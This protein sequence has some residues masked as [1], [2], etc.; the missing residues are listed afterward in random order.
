MP[1]YPVTGSHKYG[2]TLVEL[3]ISLAF[4]AVLSITIALLTSHMISSYQHGLVIKQINSSGSA[5]VE[6]FRHAISSTST[7]SLTDICKTIYSDGSNGN[8]SNYQKCINDGGH[9]LTFI[10]AVAPSVTILDANGKIPMSNV[11]LYGAFCSGTYSYIWNSGYALGKANGD[12]AIEENIAPAIFKYYKRGDSA[13]KT[14][15]NFRLLKILDSSR[16]VCT[17]HFKSSYNANMISNIFQSSEAFEEDAID[18]LTSEGN[19]DLALY[20]LDILSTTSQNSLT[21][22]IFYSGSFI[23]AT[24]SGGINVKSAG[25]Y[26]ITPDNLTAGANYDYCAINKFNFA[27]QAT[28]E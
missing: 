14:L 24:I 19:N 20:D 15:T 10:K 18:I 22:N 27:A 12:Y 16:L 5:I 17:S 11:P 9:N 28:G 7:K 6:D 25:N 26:C 13:E 8:E 1:D 3:S 4:I 23:L 2:F 21:G